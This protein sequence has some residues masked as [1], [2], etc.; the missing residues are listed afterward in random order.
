MK[1]KVKLNH[2]NINLTKA[3]MVQTL[4]ETADATKSDL[5]ESQTMPFGDDFER[6]GKTHKGGTLQNK[7]TFVDDS[8]KNLGKVSIVSDTPYARR[9]YYHPEYNFLKIHNPNA[10]GLWFNPYI[11]GSKKYFVQNAFSR[12]ARSKMK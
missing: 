2:K 1:V 7:S 11:L 4:V 8:K 6:G 5:I 10:G 12:I 9:L 3:Q